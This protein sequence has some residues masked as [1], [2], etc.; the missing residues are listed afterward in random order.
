MAGKGISWKKKKSIH[1]SLAEQLA[2]LVIKAVVIRGQLALV[3]ITVAVKF[4][5]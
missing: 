1:V 5:Q 4:A 2:Q 3:K